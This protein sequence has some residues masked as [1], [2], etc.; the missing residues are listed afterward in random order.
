V[1]AY[2]AYKMQVFGDLES[3]G[4]AGLAF[5]VPDA[6]VPGIIIWLIARLFGVA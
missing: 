4:A 1:P 5:T 2:F 6:I 3:L